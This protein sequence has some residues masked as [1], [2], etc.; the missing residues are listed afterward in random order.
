MDRMTSRG[1]AWLTLVVLA[2]AAGLVAFGVTLS[3]YGDEGF[4]LVAAQLI[5]AGKKP[6]A[7]FVYPQPPLYAYANA[8]WMSLFGQNWRVAHVFSA[9]WT[10]GSIGLAA[11]FVLARCPNP[12]WRLPAAVTAALLMGLHFTV[13]RFGTIAQAYGMCLFLI[14]AGFWL[15]VEAPDRRRPWFAAGA[16]LCAGAAAACSLLTAPVAPI[17]GAWIARR[18]RAG[19][20]S[21]KCAAFV[22]G[23]AAPFLPLLWLA[24]Q[25]PRRTLFSVVQ[26]HLF[27][28]APN[29]PR[30]NRHDL[31]VLTS[32][33]DSSQALLVALPALLG[34]LYL[35]GT[36][37]WEAE[38]RQ[39]FLLCGWLAAGLG[40]YLSAAHPTYSQYFVLLMPFLS[41][42]GALGVYAVGSTWLPNRPAAL[43]VAVAGLLALGL[44]KTLYQERAAFRF[45]WRH[46]EDIAREVNR[47]T[48]PRAEVWS[49]EAIYFAGNRIPPPGME[50]H[51]SHSLHVDPARLR[52]LGIVPRSELERS[53]A[54]GRFDTVATCSLNEYWM[55]LYRVE[56]FYARRAKVNECHLFWDKIAR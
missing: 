23:A 20:R 53:L 1:G 51:D 7:D 48:P 41:I 11:G 47:L 13:I 31:R 45:R 38:R 26:Y 34:L 28:R 44:V 39:P 19:M 50:S 37:G 14:A 33:L 5:N 4:H 25:S 17:L 36:N 40:L 2:L 55:D 9:I 12:V 30:L 3:W 6:Y 35:A 18:S 46:F 56:R 29:L 54:A 21:H 15:A 24:V 43:T 42:L 16:G 8:A 22:A 10:A 49:D 27:Y 52:S 32:W